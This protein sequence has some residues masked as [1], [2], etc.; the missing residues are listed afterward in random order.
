MVSMVRIFIATFA[1]C[2]ITS[3]ANAQTPLRIGIAGLT[4]GHVGWAFDSEKNGDIQIVGI[5][6]P[7]RNVA[8]QY[9]RK[10]GFPM[11]IVFPSLDEMLTAIKPTA[12]AAF[13]SIRQHLDVVKSCAPKG[14][15]VM[16]E[17]PLALNAV[18]AE[19]MLAL[20]RQNSVYLVTNYETTWY[21]TNHL[22]KEWVGQGKIGKLRKLVIHDGHSGPKEIGVQPEFLK[23]LTNPAENGGGAIVDFGCYGANLATWMMGGELPVSVTAVTQQLKPEIYPDVDDEAT[24]ILSY[25]EAQVIIQASWNWPYGRK[26][27]EV[28][29]TEGYIMAEDK[30]HLRFRYGT[31]E[32][33]VLEA[34]DRTPPYQDPFSYLAALVM[35]KIEIKPDDLSSMENNMTV[36]KILDAARTSAGTGR[37][38]TIK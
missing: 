10:Y 27:M 25:H 26:D 34:R 36:M 19:Q 24:I 18:H 8:L 16:V 21:Q 14:I 32:E 23:W 22:V 12:V 35:G 6:E 31:D 3:C 7:D 28:Y 11:D 30:H 2:M 4:H 38:V 20:A 17:K 37:S 15:H 9:A 33:E 29:G 1:I 5:A 13:G